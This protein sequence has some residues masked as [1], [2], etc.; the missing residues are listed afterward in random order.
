MNIDKILKQ[1]DEGTFESELEEPAVVREIQNTED[2]H[3]PTHEELRAEG[4]DLPDWVPVEDIV[5]GVQAQ[6]ENEFM[7]SE[8]ANRVWE[9]F[10]SRQ[11]KVDELSA[12]AK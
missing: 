2:R 9:M 8:L 10:Q 4:I 1:I 12:G 7:I 6:A 5:W 11:T 3:I